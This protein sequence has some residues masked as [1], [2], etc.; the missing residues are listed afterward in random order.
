M[1][2]LQPYQ[3]LPLQ[4]VEAVEKLQE[5]TNQLSIKCEDLLAFCKRELQNHPE[6]KLPV[7]FKEYVRYIA[8]TRGELVIDKLKYHGDLKARVIEDLSEIFN[9]RIANQP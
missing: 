7:I 8:M 5:I 3:S 2:V 4:R 9:Q 6:K 1:N